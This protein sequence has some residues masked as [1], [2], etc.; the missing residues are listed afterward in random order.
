[1]GKRRTGCN[2]SAPALRSTTRVAAVALTG[3]AASL[4]QGAIMIQ[5]RAEA[6][7]FL[8][9]EA[10]RLR[11]LGMSILP[12]GK[13]K[14]PANRSWTDLQQQP[15]D[16]GQIRVW[17]RKPTVTGLGIIL[18]P[19]SGHLVVRDF[20]VT[21]AF[22]AWSAAYP[23]LAQTLPIVRTHRGAH[24]YAR[25]RGI[26][27]VIIG[28]GELRGHGGYVIAPPSRHPEGTHYRWEREFSSLDDIPWLTVGESGFGERWDGGSLTGKTER[29]TER[30]DENR[31]RLK[32]TEENR[33]HEGGVIR[34][35]K[36]Q[37]EMTPW[38]QD[39]IL[40][41]VPSAPGNR[42]KAIFEFARR[43]KSRPEYADAAPSQLEELLRAWH[44][45]ALPNLGTK[46]FDETRID[47]L[48]G[49]DKIKFP[50]GTG[51]FAEA[52]KR[53]EATA[54]PNC[55]DRYD[56][57]K[58]RR[59]VGLCRELQRDNPTGP[60]FLSCWTAGTCLGIDHTTANRWLFLL[61]EDGILTLVEP[62]NTK[63]AA[64]YRYIPDD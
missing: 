34:A 59:L 14:K 20:D 45:V 58:K 21:G 5:P 11:S 25:M 52:L 23:Q 37:C 61:R 42:N 17:F 35:S 51:P 62:G 27:T 63:R 31:G 29:A 38:L 4:H 3:A 2:R 22:E 32:T 48:K 39:A 49:W 53:L 47:F 36:L 8:L 41:T 46:D 44:Q 33:S 54:L 56:D 55:A 12:I 10:L 26:S 60:F 18:G 16:E 64:R 7:S 40:S 43:L 24:V 50:H 28:D 30:T 9:H 57:L 13:G 1:M 6:G 19:V 15:A